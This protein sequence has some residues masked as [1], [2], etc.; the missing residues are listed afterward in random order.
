M[1]TQVI[2]P[3]CRKKNKKEDTKQ[4]GKRYYC[5]KCAEIVQQEKQQK[6]EDWDLLFNYICELYRIEK[7]TGMMFKQL[8][9][10]RSEPYNYTDSGMYGTLKYYYEILENKVIEGTGLGIIPYFYDKAKE[11]WKVIAEVEDSAE[12]Y[13]TPKIINITINPDL[14]KELL[15]NLQMS[16]H[17]DLKDIDWSEDNE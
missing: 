14:E 5:I 1:A 4:I 10:F 11:H 3:R 9:E 16:K 8:K 15:K 6:K 2:C 12:E 17:I 7:P 13:K